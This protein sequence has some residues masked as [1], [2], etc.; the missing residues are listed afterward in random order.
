MHDYHPW[1]FRLWAEAVHEADLRHVAK[2]RLA[3]QALAS[4]AARP[5]KA[6][7]RRQ[8]R[9]LQHLLS[10]VT[11]YSRLLFRHRATKAS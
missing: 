2:A 9:H 11:G 10:G 6:G 7:A 1:V 4:R 3:L 8:R 5:S